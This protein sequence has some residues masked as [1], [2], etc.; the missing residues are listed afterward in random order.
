MRLPAFTMAALSM[1]GFL[2]AS[3]GGWVAPAE[4]DQGMLEILPRVVAGMPR[5]DAKVPPDPSPDTERYFDFYGLAFPRTVHRFGYVE[6]GGRQI[7]VHLFNVDDSRGTALLVH[8]Y[9]DHAGILA[10]LIG[11]LTDAGLNVVVYDQPGHG[12]SDGARASIGDFGEYR[13]LFLAMAGRCREEWGLP[14]PLHIVAHS[15]GCAVVM[16]ALLGKTFS[17][18][19]G[20]VFIAPLVRSKHW[21]LSGV[22]KHVGGSFRD[23]IPRVFRNNTSDKAFRKFVK[24]DPLQPRTVPMRWVQ[25]HRAWHERIQKAPAAATPVTI[26]QGRRDTV[27]DD[28]YNLKFLEKHFPKARVIWYK[29]G[30]H[31]LMNESEPTRREVL[32]DIREALL[33]PTAP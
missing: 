6:E 1:L 8:G 25:A 15:M 33:A 21:H 29:K 18:E 7:A 32:A 5:L 4:G 31:Q 27:V 28:R 13:D 9:Y 23:E 14:G 16:D 24:N 26:L 30:G 20:V 3:A 17:P 19:G 12:L 10:P 2:A 22:G 11:S